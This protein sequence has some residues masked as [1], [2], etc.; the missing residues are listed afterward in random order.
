MTFSQLEAETAKEDDEQDTWELSQD[1]CYVA[2]TRQP[3]DA[4]A[5]I[6]RVRSPSAGAI[7][8][9]AGKNS[10][11]GSIISL[12]FCTRPV[13]F[14]L[15]SSFDSSSRGVVVKSRQQVVKGKKGQRALV[16]CFIT[17]IIISILQ[18]TG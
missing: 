16:V 3:L 6:N 14:S 15:P 12:L 10:R 1:K 11:P 17:I 13:L 7:V 2:L 4:Q 5:I 9:F 8:L 18:H